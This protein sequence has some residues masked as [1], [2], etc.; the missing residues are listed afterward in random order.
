MAAFATESR[1]LRTLQKLMER[2]LSCFVVEL[3]LAADEALA[4][5]VA[6]TQGGRELLV[7]RVKEGPVQRWNEQELS[8]GGRRPK[9]VQPGDAI[10]AVNVNEKQSAE[11]LASALRSGS[12]QTG[13]LLLRVRSHLGSGINLKEFTR[14]DDE[15]FEGDEHLQGAFQYLVQYQKQRRGSMA[16]ARGENVDPRTRFVELLKL[17]LRKSQTTTPTLARVEL[18]CLLCDDVRRLRKLFPQNNTLSFLAAVGKVR[19]QLCLY[20]SVRGRSLPQAEKPDESADA[21]L[22]EAA[23]SEGDSIGAC[24]EVSLAGADAEVASQVASSFLSI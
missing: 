8:K 9:T 22:E 23:A 18:Y 13:A 24:D 14:T 4:L 5:D 19:E 16:H 7:Q 21:S 10:V 15:T 2:H 17:W 12:R 11:E 1:Q 6:H 3:D 20:L